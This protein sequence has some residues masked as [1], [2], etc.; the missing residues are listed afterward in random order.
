MGEYIP[1][2]VVSAAALLLAL[3]LFLR[4][5]SITVVNERVKEIAGYIMD[6]SMAYL[7]RQYSVL[8]IFIVAM[9][10]V[11]TFIPSLGIKTA[12]CFLVGAIFSILSGFFGMR[13][14][15]LSNSR[16]AESASKSMKSA[17]DVA[18]S[19]GSILGLCVVG[20]GAAGLTIMY[21]IFKD[22][23]ILTGF[24]LGASSIALFCRVGG[25]IYTKAADVGA[26]LVGKVEAGI[27]EDDPRNPAVIA[28]NVGDNV[29]DV[30]GMGA[31]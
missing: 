26:D 10:L 4:N 23:A 8:A 21:L 5:K 22:M 2:L 12:I 28:D 20:F 15:T 6:G 11:L 29:G 17:L 19:G 14:A 3:I 1:V 16:T 27:P 18:F 7:R 30:A 31:G 24:T 25:G 13:S 9:F